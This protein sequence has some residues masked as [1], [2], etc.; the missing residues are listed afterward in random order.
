MS[1]SPAF[2]PGQRLR[3]IDAAS[4]P[5]GGKMI[6]PPFAVGDIVTVENASPV[7]VRLKR[8]EGLWFPARFV[9]HTDQ[10]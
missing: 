6:K 8:L 7:R 4:I 10:G 1:G 3:V 5:R 2:R 9:P